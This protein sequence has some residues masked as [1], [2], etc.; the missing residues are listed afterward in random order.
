MSIFLFIIVLTVLT[1]VAI[2]P[3]NKAVPVI[4]PILVRG[5]IPAL[6]LTTF[7][8][9][10]A[11]TP[12]APANPKLTS[13]VD[14]EL[15]IFTFSILTLVSSLTLFASSCTFLIVSSSIQ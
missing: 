15:G 1:V 5:V 11:P 10:A 3:V 12:T 4:I 6:L 2:A 8:A 7:A 9:P 13:T 14:I